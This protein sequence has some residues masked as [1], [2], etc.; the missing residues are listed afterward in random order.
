MTQIQ[1][2]YCVACGFLPRAEEVQHGLLTGLGQRAGGVLM[3]PGR[4]GVFRVSVDGELIF[5]K[6]RDSFDVAEIVRR[7][8]ARCGAAAEPLSAPVSQPRAGS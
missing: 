6:D 7:A 1:I 4:G 8:G 2:E 5:D 3:K